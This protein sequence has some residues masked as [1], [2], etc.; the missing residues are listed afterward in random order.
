[1]NEGQA[2]PAAAAAKWTG[3]LYDTTPGEDFVVD[4]RG[5]VV[6]AAGTSGHGFKFTPVLGEMAAD[7]A[8][9]ATQRLARLR[10][11]AVAATPPA[12]GATGRSP[13]IDR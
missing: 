9:G 1:M 13:M 6:V 10:L 4:R 8:L 7:L 5:A 2:A 11:P 12:P 3:C